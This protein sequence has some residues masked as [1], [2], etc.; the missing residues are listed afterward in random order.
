MRTA[1][2]YRVWIS[3]RTYITRCKSV[4]VEAASAANP[5]V[6]KTHPCQLFTRHA[7]YHVLLQPHAVIQVC[8]AANGDAHPDTVACLDRIAET[9]QKMGNFDLAE[10]VYAEALR[11]NEGMHGKRHA[12]VAETLGDLGELLHRTG[13]LLEAEDVHKRALAIRESLFGPHHELVAESCL[14]LSLLMGKLGRPQDAEVYQ[15]RVICTCCI[16]S[17]LLII[18]WRSNLRLLTTVCSYT[19]K[20]ATYDQMHGI[21]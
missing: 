15:V 14:N 18:R 6:L 7:V 4:L 19:D 9:H 17:M 1:T 11:I 5:P 2:L 13:R 8:R 12:A 20:S 3:S 16:V 21:A 10:A